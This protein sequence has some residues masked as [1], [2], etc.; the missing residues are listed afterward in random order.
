MV[1]IIR[2]ALGVLLLILTGTAVAGAII[3]ASVRPGADRQQERLS[4]FLGSA[5]DIALGGSGYLEPERN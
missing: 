3:L 1:R 2:V 5:R 4:R